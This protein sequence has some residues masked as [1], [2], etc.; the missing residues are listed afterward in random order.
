MHT[1][2]F[3]THG[4]QFFVKGVDSAQVLAQYS[5]FLLASGISNPFK[6]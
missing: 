3:S 2:A 1:K 4:Q 5:G 6:A